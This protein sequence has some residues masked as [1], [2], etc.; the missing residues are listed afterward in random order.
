MCAASRNHCWIGAVWREWLLMPLFLM[1]LFLLGLFVGPARAQLA[2]E[3]GYLLPAG[4]APGQSVEVILGGFD[5]TPDMQL[6]VHDPRIQLELLGPPGPVLVPE[7]PYWFGAKARGYAWPLAREFK[8]RLTIPADVP[9][10]LVKWQVANANGVSPV[11]TLH[12]A[13]G[14]PV[15][16]EPDRPEPQ[17]LPALPVVVSGQIR[18]LEEIDRYQF[19]VPQATP[20]TVEVISRRIGSPMHAMVQV[21]DAAGRKIADVADTE[22]RD[23][24]FSFPA[25]PNTLYTVSLHDLDFAG[26]RSY[27]YRLRLTTGPQVLAAYPAGGRRGETRPVE[28]VGPGLA[29]GGPQLESVTQPVTF[30]ATA[31][32]TSME[33]VVQTPAG[34]ALP[35]SL[36]V[37][38]GNE[39]VEGMGSSQGALTELPAAYTGSFET[40]FGQEQITFPGKQGESL[41]LV[42]QS[43]S[44]NRRLDLELVVLGPDGKELARNDDVPGSTDAELLLAIPADGTYTA[45]LTD[46]G[47]TSGSRAACYRLAIGKPVD[48][49]TVTIPALGAIPLGGQ[50]KLPVKVT[51]T[52]AF[53]EPVVL[54]LTNLPEGVTTQADLT[55]PADKTDVTIDL[56]CP[57]DAAATARL[58]TVTAT[59]TLGGQSVSRPVGPLAL[60]V[61]M[62]PRIKLTPEGLD[63]VRKVHRGSTFLAPVLIQRLEGFDG[64]IVLEMTAKQQRHRQGLA[65]DEFTVPRGAARVEYPIFVPEWLETTKTSRMILN[66]AVQVSDPKGKVR[67]LLQRQELR[68]GILPEGALMKLAHAGGEPQITP[69]ADFEVPL[70]LSRAAEFPEEVTVELVGE[71]GPRAPRNDA[72]ARFTADPL[73]MSPTLNT[74]MLRIR[75]AN[76]LPAG[77][78]YTLRLRATGL[79]QGK[80]KVM[81][82]TD[83]LVMVPGK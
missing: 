38:D 42:A 32:V 40:P 68:I 67:T 2:P 44:P 64:E 79:Q 77:S 23:Q 36:A 48:D 50:F 82:E 51:R 43:R 63:D 25:Q 12:V 49:F 39:L 76:G 66:G 30:P 27:V 16:E 62:K 71:V 41:R 33:H 81:S 70:A 24:T 35:F 78:E 8:A 55:V 28:F 13:T 15:A 37:G 65:S 19:E 56:N 5:W 53:K 18:R 3:I 21:R 9:P 72:P 73:K 60:A 34:T 45:V 69:G 52:G 61:V 22:G 54:A 47:G 31:G 80:W 58:A 57:A 17:K 46:R 1:G 59:T 26:D 75:A 20:V 14:T 4:G 10:G 83:L 74:A 7:P 11:G 29:T 6:F